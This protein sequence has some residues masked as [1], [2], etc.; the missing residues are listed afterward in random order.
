MELLVVVFGTIQ[1]E[2]VKQKSDYVMAGLVSKGRKQRQMKSLPRNTRLREQTKEKW[3][4]LVKNK[5][6]PECGTLTA[7]LYI[8][9]KNRCHKCKNSL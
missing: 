4:G 9:G 7:G 1:K 5:K 3:H 6:C 8:D 2:N